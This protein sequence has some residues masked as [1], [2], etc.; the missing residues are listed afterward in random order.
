MTLV[1]S[2]STNPNASAYQVGRGPFRP[3]TPSSHIGPGV[4]GAPSLDDLRRRLVKF[5]LADDGHSAIVNVTECADGVEVLER[6]LRKFGKLGVGQSGG[7]ELESDEGGLSIDGWAVY[8][9]WGE[10]EGPGMSVLKQS[11]LA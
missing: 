7:T 1:P 8:L 4:S 9:D 2:I 3:S 6:V 5:R 11:V 10:G